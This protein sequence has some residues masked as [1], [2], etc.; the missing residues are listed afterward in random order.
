MLSLFARA[1]GPHAA[2]YVWRQEVVGHQLGRFFLVLV[3]LARAD[4]C[5]V[6]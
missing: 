3:S 6:T 4:G 1:D 2:P 5:I